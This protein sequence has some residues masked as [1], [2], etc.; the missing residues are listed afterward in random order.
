MASQALRRPRRKAGSAGTT[1][2][3]PASARTMTAQVLSLISAGTDS[4]IVIDTAGSAAAAGKILRIG[5]LAACGDDETQ[6]RPLEHFE[7]DDAFYGCR[8]DSLSIL[9]ASFSAASLASSAPELP[10][11]KT[12]SATSR[13]SA[14]SPGAGPAHW[15][16]VA[17]VPELF[18]LFLRQRANEL[19][20]SMSQGHS[21]QCRRQN[22]YIFSC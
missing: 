10:G 16:T 3:R 5:W 11:R 7:R 4:E 6:A 9:R 12:R 21:P 15:Y 20:V 14:V 18:R 22:R 2:L 8:N 17:G 1:P 19:R 13:Q